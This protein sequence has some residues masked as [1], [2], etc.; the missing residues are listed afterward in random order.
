[1]HESAQPNVRQYH[2]R[3]AITAVVLFGVCAIIWWLTGTTHRPAP[4]P[5]V[6]TVGTHAGATSGRVSEGHA[7]ERDTRSTVDALHAAIQSHD[8]RTL[9]SA[10]SKVREC[11]DFRNGM[12]AYAADTRQVA[13][14]IDRPTGAAYRDARARMQ[15]RCALFS[16]VEARRLLTT[17]ARRLLL[18]RAARAGSLPAELALLAERA[19]LSTR[20]DYLDDLMAR[21]AASRD[22]DVARQMADVLLDERLKPLIAR[23]FGGLPIDHRGVSAWLIAACARGLDCRAHGVVATQACA[24]GAF[25]A[26]GSDDFITALM[27]EQRSEADL[28][29][30]IDAIHTITKKGNR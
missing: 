14:A 15:A 27:R 19:P 22:A 6:A 1:M 12:N 16:G 13:V 4:S 3:H 21:V 10:A 11:A 30:V 23:H 26:C 17:D 28:K 24:S 25:M 2:L 9:W 5:E 29:G 18:T 7:P 20:R 8:A